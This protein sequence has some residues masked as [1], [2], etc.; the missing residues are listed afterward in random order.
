MNAVLS[1]L[2]REEA[3]RVLHAQLLQSLFAK[4]VEAGDVNALALFAPRKTYRHGDRVQSTVAEVMQ[5]ALEHGAFMQRAMQ[6]LVNAAAGR[7]CQR[8]A[9]QL[10]AEAG[11]R[12]ADTEADFV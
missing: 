7:G 1:D 10:L 6:I 3:D 8:D 4:A 9:Q 11:E 2:E 12:W 5:T